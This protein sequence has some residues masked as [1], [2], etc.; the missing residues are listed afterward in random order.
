MPS[1]SQAISAPTS[2]E[3]RSPAVSFDRRMS[4][5]ATTR[6]CWVLVTPS[7]D[8]SITNPMSTLL[9][10]AVTTAVLV[11]LLRALRDVSPGWSSA[12]PTILRIEPSTVA[13]PRRMACLSMAPVSFVRS[14]VVAVMSC[15]S[16]VWDSCSSCAR[17]VAMSDC[18][19]RVPRALRC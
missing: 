2:A 4:C 18:S 3:S 9:L 14:P 11:W 7:S 17:R 5:L 19:T 13:S 1:A 6:S 16:T 8:R 15:C 12:V 10:W